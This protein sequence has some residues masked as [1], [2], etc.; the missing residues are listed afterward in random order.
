MGVFVIKI[1]EDTFWRRVS[2]APNSTHRLQAKQL[3]FNSNILL[4][5]LES[6]MGSCDG[7]IVLLSQT[8][9]KSLVSLPK[10]SSQEI[11]CNISNLDWLSMT[12]HSTDSE[13]KFASVLSLEVISM[14]LLHRIAIHDE[15]SYALLSFFQSLAL[16]SGMKDFRLDYRSLKLL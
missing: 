5:A 16:C 8:R 10:W 1:V 12:L 14:F 13:P 11:F 6:F 2:M 15:I 9:G 7:S 4:S 3:L